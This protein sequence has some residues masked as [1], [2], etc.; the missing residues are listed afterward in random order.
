MIVN[1]IWLYYFGAALV[2]TPS[3]FGLRSDPPTHPELIDHLAAR[4]IAGNW[5]LKQIH[6]LILN[7]ATYQ[8]A[9]IERPECRRVDAE[10]R[11]LWR[12]NR[13]RL[14]FESLRDAL[15]A[16]AGQLDLAMGGPGVELTKTPWS[17][18]RAIYGFIERQNLPSV[19]RTFD[20]ASPDVHSPQRYATTVP[21]QALFLMN[22]PFVLD[23]TR[24]LAART[25]TAG[26]VERRA[27]IETLYREALGRRPTARE[28]ELG[29]AFLAHED[30]LL[31]PSVAAT[32][33]TSAPP[34]VPASGPTGQEPPAAPPS[35]DPAG[36]SAWERYV[37]I[38]LLS[39]EFVYVD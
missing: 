38:I 12:M 36:L 32:Q 21:Q 31:A 39:N 3:D 17:P 27:Q 34:D 18:R 19:F 26:V 14:D 20:F 30:G 1:R 11:L 15:V 4:L 7:S 5:S 29:L 10:N 25:A 9:S 28:T 35:S 8:Q 24:K 23:Q 16:A 33:A 6:R 37:Q 2:R 13:K 22:S